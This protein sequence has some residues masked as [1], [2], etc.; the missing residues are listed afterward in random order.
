MIE[1]IY[2]FLLDKS[3]EIQ[4]FTSALLIVASLLTLRTQNKWLA[5]YNREL[6]QMRKMDR[7]FKELIK[8]KEKELQDLRDGK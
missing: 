3:G 2:A 1:S 4:L 7:L 8:Q 6:E 5:R